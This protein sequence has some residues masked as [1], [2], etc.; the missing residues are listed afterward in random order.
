MSEFYKDIILWLKSPDDTPLDISTNQK[1]RILAGVFL[2][3]VLIATV[4]ISLSDLIDTYVVKLEEPLIDFNPWIL[5]LFSIVVMPLIEEVIFRFP[6]KYERNYIARGLNKLLDG[7]IKLRWGNYFKYIVYFM[8]IVFG[9]VHLFN[10]D[11]TELVF[12]LLGPI[13]V[14]SQLIGGLILSYTRIKLG[15]LWAVLQ[16]GLFNLFGIII[17]LLFFHNS[18]ILYVA[19]DDYSLQVTELMFVQ[20][21]ESSFSTNIQNDTT[22]SIKAKNVNLQKVINSLSDGEESLY[23]DTWVDFH[24]ESKSGLPNSE[25]IELLKTEVKFDE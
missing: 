22:F 4:F 7:K 19:S 15:F 20:S 16:H 23:H 14:G 2:L 5:L 21:D 8:A 11:N 13:I 25:I 3:D 10:Y 1:L 18:D 9:L 17:V 24:F 12:F 6:L